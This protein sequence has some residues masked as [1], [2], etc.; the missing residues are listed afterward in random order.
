MYTIHNINVSNSSIISDEILTCWKNNMKH[1]F[2]KYVCCIKLNTSISDHLKLLKLNTLFLWNYYTVKY[3]LLKI[4][5]TSQLWSSLKLFCRRVQS[6]LDR[7]I[8]ITI[9]KLSAKSD[10][11]DES[12]AEKKRFK[13]ELILL[14]S[15]YN[16]QRYLIYPYLDLSSKNVI[17]VIL[18]I[19]SRAILI[20]FQ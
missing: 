17:W 2:M 6:V 14:L 7:I 12:I 5:I 1:I 15:L 18:N 9:F 3:V 11:G 19:N 8:I 4:I 20:S 16:K 10:R 13:I